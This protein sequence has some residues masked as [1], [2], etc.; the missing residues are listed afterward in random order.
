MEEGVLTEIIMPR[1]GATGGDVTLTEWLVQAGDRVYP[2]Q[3]LF[4]VTTD[5]ATMEVEAF[6]HG[7]FQRVLAPAGETVALGAVVALLSDAPV[8]SGEHVPRGEPET[9]PPAGTE[10]TEPADR[11]ASSHRLLASPLARRL[12]TEHGLDLAD[13][14]GT[15]ACGRIHQR[16]VRRA[17]A[18]HRSP[19]TAASAVVPVLRA[20]AQPAVRRQPA[21][22]MRRAIAARTRRSKAE[23]P[24]F[25]V[26]FV[27]D[28]TDAQDFRRQAATLAEQQGWVTPSL[29]DLALRAAALALRRTP[30]LNVSYQAD[31]VILYDEVHIG[32][33]V[34]VDDGIVVPVVRHADRQNLFTLAATT[35]RLQA[36]AAAG[37]LASSEQEG[38]TFTLSNLGMYGAESVIGVINPPEAALL[39][40]G[41]ARL[42]PAI[43]QGQI[44]PRSLMT[45][46]L[47]VDH[48]AADGV[49]ATRFLSA[50]K[51]I[52]EN[53]LLLTLDPPKEEA[54]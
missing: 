23:A 32:L 12:A 53:P 51:D 29:T 4:V 10:P 44:V 25:Y 22:P 9:P 20:T 16:D 38:S 40:L 33:V 6:R 11:R 28:M 37:T 27:I 42:Q 2:G 41:M 14:R 18:Q 46:T 8:A 52:L 49:T 45:A 24:H 30:A 43:W 31:D 36:R 48:R 15:G 21:S 7:L 17:I 1:L 13:I 26:S 54:R 19:A 47:S 34:A 3:P 50:F 39:A 35:R 5:K